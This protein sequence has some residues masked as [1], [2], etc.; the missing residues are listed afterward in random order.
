MAGLEP[1]TNATPRVGNQDERGVEGQ[2]D[3]DA[4][5]VTLQERFSGRFA[6]ER[7]PAADGAC[8]GMLDAAAAFYDRTLEE[9]QRAEAAKRLRETR[10]ADQAACVEETSPRAAT[11]ARWLLTDGDGEL[12]WALD[13]CSRAFPR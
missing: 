8:A 11:C 5:A 10:K 2:P 12:A 4:Q 6:S 1:L 13:Q 3:Y 7:V 9:P